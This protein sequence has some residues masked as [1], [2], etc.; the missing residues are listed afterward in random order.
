MDNSTKAIAH[1]IIAEW[2]AIKRLI[3]DAV[4]VPHH[5]KASAKH[6]DPKPDDKDY[7]QP[8][9]LANR[10]MSVPEV[11]PANPQEDRPN[12]EIKNSRKWFKDH[13][14]EV[15]GV[16]VVAAYTAVAACQL[17]ATLEA[18]NLTRR[19]FER[20]QRPYIW[21]SNLGDPHLSGLGS[22]IV[23]TWHITNYG[24]IPAQNLHVTQESKIRGGD[25]AQQFG[26]VLN[27]GLGAPLPS[28]GD[29]FYT[30]VFPPN[31]PRPVFDT[32]Y[33][34]DEHSCPKQLLVP[35]LLDR[36]SSPGA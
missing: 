5:D 13:G 11:S 9:Q 2:E 17:N 31:T 35:A 23:W 15:L 19:H 6:Y 26:Q 18:N 33:S 27:Q 4:P 7:K 30:V 3:V 21:V 8:A 10:L 25:Y 24:R 28:G 16:I 36:G 1:K 14:V 12:Q 34:I 22:Q 32:L 29:Q 20:E